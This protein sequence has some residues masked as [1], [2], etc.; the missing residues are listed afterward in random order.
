[1]WGRQCCSQWV[2]VEH[3]LYVS[4]AAHTALGVWS[5][6][7]KVVGVYLQLARIFFSSRMVFR[8]IES[9]GSFVNVL[10]AESSWREGIFCS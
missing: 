10:Y 2:S 7:D 6:L 1:M 3:L 4:W 9:V 5:Q 8:S